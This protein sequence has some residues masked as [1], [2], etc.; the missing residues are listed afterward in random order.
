MALINTEVPMRFKKTSLDIMIPLTVLALIVLGT[1]NYA[2]L[3]TNKFVRFYS[4]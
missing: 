2:L 1:G 4:T 3:A